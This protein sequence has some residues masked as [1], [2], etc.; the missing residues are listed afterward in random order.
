MRRKI[1][2]LVAE[3]QGHGRC[4]HV[5]VALAGDHLAHIVRVAHNV[6]IVGRQS[7]DGYRFRQLEIAG[8]SRCLGVRAAEHVDDH[9]LHGSCVGERRTG[10]E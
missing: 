8:E 7:S 6:G 10:D 5:R 4:G 1:R 2:R 3:D 9:D